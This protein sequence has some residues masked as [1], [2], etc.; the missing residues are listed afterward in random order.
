[1]KRQ[2][3]A[4]FAAAI[5][6]PGIIQAQGRHYGPPPRERISSTIVDCQ[7]RTVD[8]RRSLRHALDRSSLN[9]TR[10]EDQLNLDAERLEKSMI[11]VS[12]SWNR[13][14]DAPRA[15]NY[16]SSAIGVG[17]DINRTMVQRRLSPDVQRQWDIVRSE[18]NH[19]AEVFDLPRIRW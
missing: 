7:A 16:V 14:H 15:R 17:Q 5:L 18:L 12:E 19:L 9:N 10:R 2:V 4:L 3:Q 1:M 11:R 13:Y 8:F 6:L